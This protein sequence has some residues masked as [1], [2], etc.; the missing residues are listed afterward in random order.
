MPQR[1]TRRF[2]SNNKPV[3]LRVDVSHCKA[4]EQVIV[5]CPR[6]YATR[7]GRIYLKRLMVPAVCKNGRRIM[8]I[9][10]DIK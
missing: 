4:G 7:S 9:A 8:L 10:D 5:S 1:R 3:T 6:H 2:V